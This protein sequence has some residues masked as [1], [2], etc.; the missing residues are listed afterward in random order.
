LIFAASFLRLIWLLRRLRLIS[1][2]SCFPISVFTL[3]AYCGFVEH[4]ESLSE[5]IQSLSGAGAGRYV[6]VRL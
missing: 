4:Y 5:T 2:L 3:F 6:R 1:L